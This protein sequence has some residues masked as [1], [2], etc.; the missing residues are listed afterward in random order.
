[1]QQIGKYRWAICALLF[2]ATTINYLD[3]AIISL[4]KEYLDEE[5]KWSKSDYANVTVAFQL[6]YAL[7]MVFVGRLIDRLGT[8]LG[9]A[10]SLISW[11]IAAMGH[12]LVGSNFGF[13]LARIGL[14]ITESGNF[15]AAIK[16]VSEWFP[17]KER[18]F[19]TGILNSGSNIGAVI[20]PLIVPFIALA[21]GWRLTFVIVGAAGLLWLVFWFWLYETPKRQKRLSPAEYDYIHSDLDEQAAEAEKPMH[22][23]T[24][25]GYRQSWAY[26][27]GKFLTDG[28]W[29]FYLFWLPDFLK[30][31]YQLSKTAL[32]LPVATVYI[33]A[34]VGS[35]A[36]GWLPMYFIGKGW[37]VFRARKTAMLLYACCALP[38]LLAQV[39]GS[40]NMWYAILVIGFATGAHQAWSANIYTTVSDALPKSAVGFVIGFGGMTGTLGAVLVSK[41]AGWLFDYYKGLG[42]IETGYYIMFLVSG[43]A[44]L[45]A[46]AGMHILVPKEPL[47][48]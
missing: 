19:A 10:L 21:Y 34:T 14:G 8:K 24:A 48:V 45:T 23:R 1:M 18:A 47:R 37:P 35:V 16:T 17:K 32:A 9:Y 40:Y 2:F 36:G 26:A 5:F 11:S 28:I 29:W 31:Q 41:V 20:A 30:E 13:Y 43:L 12:F 39:A 4:V 15:P 22:W 3:R 46:W 44:Y 27:L 7:A 33:L 42:H 6:S 25:L 38:V